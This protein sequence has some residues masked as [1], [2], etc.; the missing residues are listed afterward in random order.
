MKYQLTEIRRMQQLAGVLKEAKS[1]EVKSPAYYVGWQTGPNR[2]KEI[3]TS[4]EEEKYILEKANEL[5]ILLNDERLIEF[6]KGYVDS[7]RSRDVRY[8]GLS[9]V[10]KA[11]LAA[12][13]NK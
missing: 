11:L 7:V 5:Y 8:E 3:S 4:P 9:S 1:K 10:A 6:A 2:R 13:R 12:K